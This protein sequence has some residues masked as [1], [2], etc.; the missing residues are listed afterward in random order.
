MTGG[1]PQPNL[2]CLEDERKC[3]PSVKTFSN[4]DPKTFVQELL[5]K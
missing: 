3:E 1:R 5:L 4:N 2:L